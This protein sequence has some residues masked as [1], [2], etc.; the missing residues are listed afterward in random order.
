MRKSMEGVL[1]VSGILVTT[2]L[3]GA[4]ASIPHRPSYYDGAAQPIE[5]PRQVQAPSCTDI[6]WLMSVQ[7]NNYFDARVYINGKSVGLLPGMMA[8]HVA[9]P[10]SRSMLDAR[11]CMVVFV[12][13]YPDMKTAQS[14]AECPV[15]GSRLELAI[16]DSHSGFPLRLWLQDWR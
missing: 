12:K 16:E 4:C 13:L 8:K 2:F 9:I 1:A 5:A 14:S 3:M 15:P 6:C 11:G 10:I 7:N